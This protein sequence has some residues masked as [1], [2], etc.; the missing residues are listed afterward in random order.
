[1][2]DEEL[3]LI[4]GGHAVNIWAIRYQEKIKDELDLLAPFTSKDLDLFGTKQT[5][6]ILHK[7][8]GGKLQWSAPRGPVIGRLELSVKNKEL[9][10]EVLHS[11]H[12]LK[13]IKDA[14]NFYL[15]I[16]DV[17]AK[18]LAPLPLLQCK[19]TNAASI[20]QTERQDVKHVKIMIL[21]VRE[22]LKETL[23]IGQTQDVSG[24]NVLKPFSQIYEIIT[25]S[26]AEKVRKKWDVDF[27]KVWPLEQIINS[28]IPQILGF[29]Q[30][31]LRP[32]HENP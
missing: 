32:L 25:S 11:V 19:I 4:I 20:S 3:P 10:V 14:D 5:L 12:G 21:C 17:S 2:D 9:K 16:H 22:F 1:M 8:Y 30:H 29:Y 6:E 15:T 13:E 24:R 26:E 31:Q 27:Q 28:D 18:V 7:K 23:L